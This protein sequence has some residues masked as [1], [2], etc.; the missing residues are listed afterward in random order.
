MYK[1]Q[2]HHLGN[3]ALKKHKKI[4]TYLQQNCSNPSNGF[5]Q[6]THVITVIFCQDFLYLSLNQ[7]FVQRQLCLFS[8]PEH[9]MLKVSYFT[10]VRCLSVHTTEMG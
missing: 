4:H 7:T 1:V 8:S 9:N 2:H 10:S 3:T 5:Q 6:A